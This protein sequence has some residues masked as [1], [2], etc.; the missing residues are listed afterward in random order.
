MR[1]EYKKHIN[2]RIKGGADCIVK[3]DLTCRDRN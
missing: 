1:S 3:F 2:N